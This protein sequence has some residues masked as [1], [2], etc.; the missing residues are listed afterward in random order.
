MMKMFEPILEK[1]MAEHIKSNEAMLERFKDSM[2]EVIHEQSNLF[3]TH[4]KNVVPPAPT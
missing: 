3:L 1:K 2:L 4:M